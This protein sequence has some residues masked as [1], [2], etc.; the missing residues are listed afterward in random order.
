MDT[1][2]KKGGHLDLLESALREPGLDEGGT[3]VIQTEKKRDG[4]GTFLFM[5]TS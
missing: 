5:T 4:F 1:E 2:L 3:I